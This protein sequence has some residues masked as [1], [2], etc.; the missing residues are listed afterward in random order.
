MPA[1]QTDVAKGGRTCAEMSGFW[2]EKM[3]LLPAKH[4]DQSIK[5]HTQTV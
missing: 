2:V 1:T 4:G 5:D 3:K